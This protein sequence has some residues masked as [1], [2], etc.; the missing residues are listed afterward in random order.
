MAWPWRAEGLAVSCVSCFQSMSPV[1]LLPPPTAGSAGA[2]CRSCLTTSS[3]NVHGSG[4]GRVVV[5]VVGGG[6]V[7]VVVEVV[8]AR[9]PVTQAGFE[10]WGTFPS[11]GSSR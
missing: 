11:T 5:V 3:R 2:R 8:G 6:S 4:S 7:V 1:E 10:V 9:A